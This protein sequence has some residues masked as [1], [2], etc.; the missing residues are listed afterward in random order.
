MRKWFFWLA[1][2][3]SAV[4]GCD[5][6][7]QP[8]L[9]T[10]GPEFVPLRVGDYRIYQVDSVGTLINVSTAYNFQLKEVVTDSF[11]NPT[12]GYTYILSRFKRANATSPWVPMPTWQARNDNREAVVVE[13]NT[14]F[15]KLVFPVSNQLSWNGNSYNNLEGKDN[16][17]D[18]E[19]F[20]CDV[21]MCSM[22]VG[23]YAAGNNLTFE[24]TVKVQEQDSP[25]LISV[26]DVRYAVY[27]KGV[28]LIERSVDFK[29]YCSKGACL[30]KGLIDK[31]WTYKWTLI[32]YGSN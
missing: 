14:S 21:Y 24:N 25:D 27:A 17:G 2:A 29:I 5:E 20:D 6:S 31:G 32:E 1:F 16:C 8:V 15:V 10:Q 18:N 4:V 19:N 7:D 28:G 30:G 9:L 13:G 11:R 23:S 12:G 26:H 22:V 3:V